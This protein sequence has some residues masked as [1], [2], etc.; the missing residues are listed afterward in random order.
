MIDCNGYVDFVIEAGIYVVVY[1]VLMLLI[2]L[3]KQE[4]ADLLGK[5]RRKK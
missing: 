1:G 2:G 4:K 3:N 5:L